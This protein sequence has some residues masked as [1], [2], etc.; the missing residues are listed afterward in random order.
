MFRVEREQCPTGTVPIKRTTQDDLIRAKS[1]FSNF[2][3][4]HNPG[5]HVSFM[6]YLSI[7]NALNYVIIFFNYR[8]VI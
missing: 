7:L 6:L 1:F 2:M 3:S 8:V 4:E 5:T